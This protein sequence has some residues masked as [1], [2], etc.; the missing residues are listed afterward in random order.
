VKRRRPKVRTLA[1]WGRAVRGLLE[2]VDHLV[3]KHEGRAPG[4]GARPQRTTEA[5]TEYTPQQQPI[6]N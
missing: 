6:K 1:A 2:D 5:W 3:Q 4:Q